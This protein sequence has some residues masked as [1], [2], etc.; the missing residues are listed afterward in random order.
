MTQVLSSQMRLRVAL[1]VVLA[2]SFSLPTCAQ[3]PEKPLD[4]ALTEFFDADNLERR[5]SATKSI[6]ALDSDF[7]TLRSK[8]RSGR[9]YTENAPTGRFEKAG[10]DCGTVTWFWFRMTT[11][12]RRPILFVSTFTEA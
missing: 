12:M 4:R 7:E 10:T 6:L 11:I 3:S 8:L 2:V 5:V 9:I 1:A